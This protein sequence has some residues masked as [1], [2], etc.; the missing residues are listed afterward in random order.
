MSICPNRRTLCKFSGPR[1]WSKTQPQRV[2]G[3]LR[4]MLRTQPR[5]V[6]VAAPPRCAVSPIC[7]RQHG[8]QSQNSQFCTEQL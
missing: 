1:L 3:A 7:N 5:S 8:N 6:L 2:S 4:L